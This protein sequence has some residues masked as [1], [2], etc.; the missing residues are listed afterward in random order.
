ME[1][2]PRTWSIGINW[3]KILLVIKNFNLIIKKIP[4]E[5]WIKGTILYCLAH[6]YHD[7]RDHKIIIIKVNLY[8]KYDSRFV[9]TKLISI[10]KFI[11]Q[12]DEGGGF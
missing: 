8:I 3:E 6:G 10:L 12:V 4:K 2:H 11:K 5:T 9:K 7:D 1:N